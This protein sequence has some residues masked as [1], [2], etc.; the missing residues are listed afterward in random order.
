M[1]CLYFHSTVSKRQVTVDNEQTRLSC[2][3]MRIGVWWRILELGYGFC[4]GVKVARDII[5]AS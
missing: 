2:P 5:K 4:C 1:V 3:I